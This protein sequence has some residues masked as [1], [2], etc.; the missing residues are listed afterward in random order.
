[1]HDNNFCRVSSQNICAC[2]VP[3]HAETAL[4][5]SLHH[6]EQILNSDDPSS[7]RIIIQDSLGEE[8]KTCLD[9]E[10]RGQPRLNLLSLY[11]PLWSSN[12]LVLDLYFML[13][14]FKP[15]P[16]TLKKKTPHSYQLILVQ[17][18]SSGTLGASIYQQDGCAP[19]TVPKVGWEAVWLV[20]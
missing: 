1:M 8:N 11:P 6:W 20:C 17:V 13:G 7:K 9:N 16:A 4:Q 12:C 19:S 14:E 2:Q 5:I 15:L 3:R 18:S 10:K